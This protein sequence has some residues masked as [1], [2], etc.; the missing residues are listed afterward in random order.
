MAASHVIFV[1]DSHLSPDVQGTRDNWA[2]VVRHVQRAAPDLVIHLGDLSFDGVR[3]P[4]ELDYARGQLDLLPVPW[5]AIPGNHDVGDNPLPDVPEV[6]W[7]TAARRQ[8]WLDVVGAD[9][10]SLVIGD[11]TLLAVNA[12]LGGSGLAAEASQW[13]W[14]EDQLR[15]AGQDQRIALLAHKPLTASEAEIAAAPRYRFWP[16]A[17]RD[18]LGRLFAGRPPALFVSGHVHQSR[19]LRID[20]TDHVWVPT[21]WAVL[22]DQKEPP[23][24]AKRCGV[25]SLRF[26]PDRAP[27][28]EFCEPDGIQ[29][30]TVTADIQKRFL[31]R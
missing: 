23:L 13:S 12:Q 17:A 2:A 20:G 7:V 1:S 30:L 11:W 16:L 15:G 21:S 24:G 25:L 8:R 9:Y 10:W 5:T 3:N 29:Q 4:A 6:R 14:L 26:A 19:Q 27:E 18:R 31:G 22:P 28:P